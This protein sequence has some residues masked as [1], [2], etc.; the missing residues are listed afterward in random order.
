MC[1]KLTDN[2]LLNNRHLP[3]NI[4]LQMTFIIV[5]IVTRKP[6]LIS[7]EFLVDSFYVYDKQS[8]LIIYIT[9]IRLKETKKGEQV[10]TVVALMYS[11]SCRVLCHYTMDL[12]YLNS[13]ISHCIR[14]T[15]LSGNVVSSYCIN[16]QI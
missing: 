9:K 8:F 7:F 13:M 6:S 3:F 4:Y 1:D 5:N 14:K 12:L 2:I 15:V 16:N 10:V 11:C